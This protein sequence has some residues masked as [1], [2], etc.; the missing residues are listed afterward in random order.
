MLNKSLPSS[1]QPKEA[2]RPQWH[3]F[4]KYLVKAV[5][6]EVTEKSAEI[7]KST[8]LE[9]FGITILVCV[10]VCEWAWHFGN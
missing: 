4:R 2:A 7:E 3:L 5:V 8:A 10:F 6:Q 1:S 9:E